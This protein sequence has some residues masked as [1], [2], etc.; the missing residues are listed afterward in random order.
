V[1]WAHLAAT[2]KEVQFQLYISILK[3]EEP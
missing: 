3:T 1:N 2:A